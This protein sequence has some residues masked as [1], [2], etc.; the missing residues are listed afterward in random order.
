[1]EIIDSQ[2]G[3]EKRNAQ[4]Q[5][6]IIGIPRQRRIAS[7]IVHTQTPLSITVCVTEVF[8]LSTLNLLNFQ[9]PLSI[10]G[11]CSSS[12]SGSGGGGEKRREADAGNGRGSQSR[13]ELLP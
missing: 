7:V 13:D 4:L 10:T 1:M 2:T 11:V 8:S 5:K 6:F 12:S 3:F 9:S